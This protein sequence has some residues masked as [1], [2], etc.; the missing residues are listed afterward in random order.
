MRVAIYARTSTE[1]Q[2]LEN[3]LEVLY[4]FI[5]QRG[6]NLVQVYEEQESAWKAGH[7]SQLAELKAAAARREFDIVLT[8]ALDRLSRE[9]AAAILNLVDTLKVYGVKVVSYQEAWTEAPGDIG[10]ILYAIAGWVAKM[11]SQRRSERTKAG[12]DRVRSHGSKS[13]K[14]IGQRGKDKTPRKRSG[15]YRRWEL[16]K[17]A[18]ANQA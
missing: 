12:L 9:G 15:Y 14:G 4:K 3:Q 16:N 1:R 8:W 7:Q 11:E 18:A 13:G 10:E 5:Q 6:W 17:G 2:E